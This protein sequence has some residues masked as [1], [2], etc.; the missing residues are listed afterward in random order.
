MSATVT[1]QL[2]Q[3][4]ETYMHSVN[5]AIEEG[6]EKLAYQLG[7]RYADEATA[8]LGRNAG[9]AGSA[10]APGGSP[11]PRRG[12]NLL[13]RLLHRLDGY[14]LTVFNPSAHPGLYAASRRDR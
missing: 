9:A 11:P 4:R 2:R 7:A 3:L 6:R 8:L 1:V 10:D 13:G 5:A 12:T 14:T